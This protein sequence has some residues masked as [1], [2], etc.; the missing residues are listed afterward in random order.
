[1][2]ANLGRSVEEIQRASITAV[3]Q[4]QYRPRHRMALIGQ[5]PPRATQTPGEFDPRE[6]STGESRRRMRL[7]N[8]ASRNSTAGKPRRQKFI[9]LFRMAQALRKGEL[10]PK[11]G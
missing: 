7:C 6:I 9:P 4:D 1:M 10:D 2:A 11:F 3:P 5:S 8:H